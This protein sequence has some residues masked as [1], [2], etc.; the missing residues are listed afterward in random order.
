MLEQLL[1]WFLVAVTVVLVTKFTVMTELHMV[2]VYL[3]ILFEIN[4]KFIC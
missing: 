3:Y 1:S 2:S 4:L